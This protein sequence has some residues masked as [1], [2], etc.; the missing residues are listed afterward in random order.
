M[1]EPKADGRDG[2]TL[3]RVPVGPDDA[4]WHGCL[5]GDAASA[6]AAG[7][8]VSALREPDQLETVLAGRESAC[9]APPCAA[10]REWIAG[11]G[12]QQADERELMAILD[13]REVR[14]DFHATMSAVS[15]LYRYRIHNA[16]G[17]PVERRVQQHTYHCW[18][19]PAVD[20][21]REPSR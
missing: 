6:S 1:I 21:M 19:D 11:A 5:P 10:T 18:L 16:T 12:L 13:M 15:K 14:G 3:L 8:D 2:C 7:L 20:S 9:V 17:R 4:L